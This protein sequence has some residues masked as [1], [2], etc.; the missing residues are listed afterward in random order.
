MASY[1]AVLSW[2]TGVTVRGKARAP[3]TRREANEL[4][5]T[6]L[7]IP[8]GTRVTVRE[9]YLVPAVGDPTVHLATVTALVYEPALGLGI[10]GHTVPREGSVLLGELLGTAVQRATQFT[11]RIA[12]P[13]RADVPA[14]DFQAR[15]LLAERP[16]AVVTETTYW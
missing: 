16:A 6:L 7:D 1:T 8:P 9:G 13:V 2:W 5:A 4:E 3:D 10:D 12:G 15:L 11:V 14:L